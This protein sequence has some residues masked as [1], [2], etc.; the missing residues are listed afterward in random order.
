M[1]Q[2]SKILFLVLLSVLLASCKPGRPDGVLSEKKMEN[3]LYDYHIAKAMAHRSDSIE[4]NMQRY[5]E[6]VFRKHKV[7]QAVFDS[8]M[9]YYTRHADKLYAIYEKLNTRF[10]EAMP[11]NMAALNTPHSNNGETYTIWSGRPFN[12]LSSQGLNRIYFEQPCDTTLLPGDNLVLRFSNEWLYK[13]GQKMATA[14]LAVC[15]EGDS[16]VSVSRTVYGSGNQTLSM[17]VAER[18]PK[19]VYG[20]IYNHSPWSREAKLLTISNPQL[21]RNRIKVPNKKE[22]TENTENT[23][24]QKGNSKKEDTLRTSQRFTIKG[25]KKK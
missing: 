8:S 7:E 12:L 2:I 6:A 21:V 1:K 18:K 23:S 11:A 10:S 19:L 15:Y 20:F 4:Q 17:R 24:V 13:E 9:R 5:T 14:V 16:I 25:I 22:E 3:I